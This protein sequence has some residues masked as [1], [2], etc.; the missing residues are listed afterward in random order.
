[1]PAPKPSRAADRNLL[2]GILAL[3]MDFV[4]RDQ[5]IAGMN[6]WVLDKARSLGAILREHGAMTA[7]ELALLEPLVAKH[8][9]KHGND[10]QQSL[11]VLSS[12]GS[13]R[14]ELQ[15]IADPE[16]QASLAT[17]SSVPHR[18]PDPHATVSTAPANPD[19]H[20]TT[21]PS[22]TSPAAGSRFRILRPHARGGLGEVYVARDEEL[23]RE[24]ALK[25]IQARHADH[26]ENRARFVLEAEVTGALEHP[27][28]V[29]VYGL[30][31]YADGRPFYAMRFIK[32]D[33]LKDAIECFHQQDKPGRDS[34]EREAEL[35]KLLRRFYDVCNALAYAHSRGVLHRDL[36]PGNIMLGKY[37]E[38]LVVD[39]GLAKAQGKTEPAATTSLAEV[40]LRPS[41]DSGGSAT[42]TGSVLGT[43]A[44]MSPEQAAGRLDQLGPASDVY[45]LGATLYC[46]LTGQPPFTER[47]VLN[48]LAKVQRGEIV[49]PR[50]VKVQV[51]PAL[52]AVCMKAMALRPEDRYATAAE[53]G[54]DVERW[55]NDQPVLAWPE[56]WQ[57]RVRR[58]MN[59]HRVLVTAS[60][61]A[62]L[63]A[64]ASLGVATMLLT[65]AN[66]QLIQANQ[67][68]HRAK[69]EAA[70]RAEEEA[71]AKKEAESARVAAADK[72]EAA[73]RAGDEAERARLL[74]EQRRREAA[75]ALEQARATLWQIYSNGL[76]Q[77]DRERANGN[78]ARAEEILETCPPALRSW[79]W[80][81]RRRL[82]RGELK[83]LTGL[84][85]RI[86]GLAYSPDGRRLASAGADG[87]VRLWDL[88]SGEELLQFEKHTRPVAMVAFSAD[89]S[90]LASVTVADHASLAKSLSTRAD[91][92]SSPRASS[93]HG[94]LIVWEVATGKALLSL[95]GYHSVSFSANGLQITAPSAA[96]TVKTWDAAT[97]AELRSFTGHPG[98]ATLARRSAD[99]RYLVAASVDPQKVVKA[100]SMIPGEL[101]IWDLQ[102][103]KA[104]RTMPV[105]SSI[106]SCT[107]SPDGRRLAAAHGDG[108]V[109]IWDVAAGTR[110]DFRPHGAHPA[111]VAFSPDGRRLATGA[112]LDGVTKIWDATDHAQVTQVHTTLCGVNPLCLAFSPD[113]RSLATSGNDQTIKVWDAHAG[114]GALYLSGHG[115]MVH[116]VAFQP[117]ARRVASVAGDGQ[118]KVWN[119]DTGAELASRNC[120]DTRLVFSPD[121]KLLATAGGASQGEVSLWD[122][123][124]YQVLRTLAT[125]TTP[126]VSVAFSADGK[127]L[128]SGSTRFAAPGRPGSIQIHDVSSGAL[129][130][131]FPADA[132]HCVTLG[133]ENRSIIAGHADHTVKVWDASSG[134]AIRTLV[135]QE[136]A[137]NAVACSPDGTLVAA[138]SG[139]ARPVPA[140][141]KVWDLN[142][143]REIHT[144]VGHLGL[145]L[146][147]A[148]SPD[149]R[150]LA[151]ASS[152]LADKGEV[153]LWDLATGKEVAS[154][155]GMAAVAFSADG[156]QLASAQGWLFGA[157]QVRIW[158]GTPERD[159]CTLRGHTHWINEVA[160]HPNHLHLASASSDKTLKVWDLAAGREIRTLHGHTSRVF[161]VAYRP[162]G[163]Q[164]ASA[165]ED[166]TVR[167]WNAV[168]GE[169]T[170]VLRGHRERVDSVRYSPDGRLVVS[171]SVDGTVKVWETSAGKEV[172]SLNGHSGWVAC[173]VFSP[174]G[175]RIVSSGRASDDTGE[176]M[177]WETDTGKLL[178]RLKGHA[179]LVWRVSFSHDGRRLVSASVDGAVKIWDAADGAE[180]L[181]CR[182]HSGEAPSVDW[183]LDDAQIASA[184]YDGMINIWDTAR[185]SRITGLQ[186]H[187]QR[188]QTI[189]FSRD[190]KWLASA[191]E[192]HVIKIWQAGRFE[193]APER[194][195]RLLVED[196]LDKHFVK[197]VVER[198]LREDRSVNPE[199]RELALAR[200]ELLAPGPDLLAREVK[201]LGG[202]VRVGQGSMYDVDLKETAIADADLAWLSRVKRVGRLD[203]SFT[204]VTDR[205]IGSLVRAKDLVALDL[206]GTQVTDAG[207]LALRHLP[208][209]RSLNVAQTAVS[210][211]AVQ[212]LVEG[213][214]L[215]LCRVGVGVKGRI[216]VEQEYVSG[217]LHYNRLWVSDTIY[218]NYL[219]GQVPEPGE[220]VAR[221][222]RREGTTYY[223]RH[224]PIGQVMNKLEW[225]KPA[226]V[227][228][229][230]SDVRLPASLVGLAALPASAPGNLLAGIWSEPAIGVVRLN[231]GTPAV[232]GR[233]LQHLHFYNSTPAFKKFCLP[234]AGETTYFG[235]IRDAMDR[236]CR[237]T[238]L[239]GDERTLLGK[240]GPRNFY[241]ALFIEMAREDLR[242]I[243]TPFLTREALEEMMDCL[244]DSGVVC[245][246]TSNRYYN[247]A[248][249]IIDAARS[250]NLAWKVGSD[251]GDLSPKRQLPSHWGSEWV[252][253]ARREACL[254]HLVDVKAANRDL[255]WNVP[256]STG[257][258]LWHDGEAPDLGPLAK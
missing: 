68:E 89:G 201:R 103:S 134:Q 214:D 154:L 25:E 225:F 120:S 24:V 230:P 244:V 229:Y 14:D 35:R 232:Y 179:G 160:W 196:L 180:L 127:Q 187:S 147:L 247:L 69:L 33:S 149:G 107:F 136:A 47:D 252:V 19:P 210:D 23:S 20:A 159:R 11:Q 67:A 113:G 52:E 150:R 153:K 167:L 255:Q 233:P 30:G 93:D 189:A 109:S 237:I 182:G 222:R 221:D 184:G 220:W 85:S 49:P 62:L 91:P 129:L 106:A 216:R 4:T 169:E 61:A 171:A 75:D 197:Q 97:G 48:L 59:R 251:R 158:N 84:V 118:L 151:S 7:D 17:I 58:W 245:F 53:L 66:E 254:Q 6:A 162:D 70:Q 165:G 223:H 242:D 125:G 215:S 36:K 246:H 31:T 152:N 16:V 100:A 3:Q 190:G 94:E 124:S 74:A 73:R 29:P 64:L 57:M 83:T 178:L 241:S 39:W 212:Q 172:R 133:P 123:R 198:Q 117:G 155:P 13:A 141:I 195:A 145:I 207:L 81:Y 80:H 224:G 234:P 2:F 99:G 5:L 92:G 41:M 166:K 163:V 51:P 174:D 18:A 126:V 183:G 87:M 146:N 8:I 181:A 170:L 202:S 54:E 9:E 90:R 112:A 38:T 191:G 77:A 82:C 132:L 121:G 27:G 128:V 131:S 199:V 250:L 72:A 139:G 1:M 253:V 79:E 102:G 192:D 211:K 137:I 43:P 248:P 235:F 177:V 135:G 164:L 122:V 101:T 108:T 88:A 15:Q 119:A 78:V 142:S 116:S 204:R 173:A 227:L 34:A 104:P 12:V 98:M 240:R 218:G 258:H 239:D 95:P 148:F 217:K 76:A 114:Q 186:G 140:A 231:V 161:G 256:T 185:G 200:L 110:I 194:Q 45:S 188:L 40:P 56:P 249:P 71:R 226:S 10:P 243:N 111:E 32:G 138:S 143:G 28:I 176:I 130:K 157:T 44:F 60:A 203:L 205:G 193:T 55:L 96:G 228:A 65:A 257:R 86:N 175:K 26:P 105:S 156:H 206:A 236:G 37:G 42:Q 63:V 208:G 213:R 115:L 50:Q 168:T 238:V 144:L 21:A 46:L 22:S 209:L 219:A